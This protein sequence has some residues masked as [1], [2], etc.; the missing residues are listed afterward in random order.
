[1]MQCSTHMSADIRCPR[2]EKIRRKISAVEDTPEIY[3]GH[4]DYGMTF[5][6]KGTSARS[7]LI[8]SIGNGLGM[9]S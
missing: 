8:T 7:D 5:V 9:S 4:I 1:M 3:L 2:L 6:E